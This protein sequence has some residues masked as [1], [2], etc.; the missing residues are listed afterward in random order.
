MSEDADKIAGLEADIESLVDMLYR[1]GGVDARDWLWLNYPDQ[2]RDLA[3][4][5]LIAEF[6]AGEP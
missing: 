2:T 3:L 4:G 1:H 5:K 6:E